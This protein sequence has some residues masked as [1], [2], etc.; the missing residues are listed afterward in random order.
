MAHKT[1][2]RPEIPECAAHVW[3]WF[4][5]LSAQRMSGMGGA[6]PLGW[7]GIAAW[8]ALT[9][10]IVRPEE[11]RMLVAMDAAYREAA[12]EEQEDRREAGK[13]EGGGKRRAWS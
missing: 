8:A 2:E 13:A 3:A 7:S 6:E 11:V 10:E 1:P 5:E 4:A 12:A 9:G